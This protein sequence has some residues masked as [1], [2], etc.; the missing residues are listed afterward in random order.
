M[1]SIH[2]ISIRDAARDCI[3]LTV[4]VL[5]SCALYIQGL[6]FYSDDW[7]FLQLLGSAK[8]RSFSGL[9]QALYDGDLVIRQRP[10]QVLQFTALY[11]LFGLQP[12]GYHLVNAGLLVLAAMLFYL[13]LRE[14]RLPH[15]LALSIPL[16]YALLPH[17]STDRFWISVFQATLSMDLYF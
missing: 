4:T 16:G 11:R 12:F 13:A 7:V 10:L 2:V 6:G 14:L 5:I 1:D 8:D 3:F 17:Y 9:L 15:L